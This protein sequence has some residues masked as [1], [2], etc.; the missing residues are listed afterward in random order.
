MH[1]QPAYLRYAKY[2]NGNAVKLFEGGICLPSG[3]QLTDAQL[4]N[5]VSI[6]NGTLAKVGV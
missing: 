4:D 1:L 6:V 2:L 3:S 5:I